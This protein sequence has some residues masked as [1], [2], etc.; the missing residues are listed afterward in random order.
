MNKLPLHTLK[1]FCKSLGAKRVSK[2]FLLEL[3]KILIEDLEKIV[4]LAIE[5]SKNEK[6]NTIL[7]RDV[8]MAIKEIIKEENL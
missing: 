4:L 1:N 3:E 7:E 6:R 8:E 5:F 2:E